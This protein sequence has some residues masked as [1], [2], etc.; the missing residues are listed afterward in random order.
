MSDATARSARGLAALLGGSGLLHLVLPT[1]YRRI[2]PAPLKRWDAEVVAVSGVAELACAALLLAPPTRRLGGLASATLLAAVFPAN[3]QMALDGG[4][5]DAPFPA[6]SRL[7]TWLR[8]PLQLP[9][10]AMAVRIWR[11]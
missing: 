6:N 11:G 9:L 1:P 10:I 3:V 2:V 5:D 4:Y 7:L 8:L